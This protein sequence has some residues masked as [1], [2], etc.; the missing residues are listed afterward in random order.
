MDIGTMH[1]E[2]H[3]RRIMLRIAYDGTNY[4]GW[5][6]QENGTAVEEVLNKGLCEL[7]GEEIA[8]IGASRTDSGVHALGNVA[9][10][11]TESRIPAEKFCLAV[12]KYLPDDIAVQSSCEVSPDF[13]PRYAQC[14]KTYEYTIYNA[15]IP[16]P[17][18][19]R[20]SYFVHWPLKVDLMN[21][22]VGYLVGE[23]DFAGFCS[24]G[25]QVKTT[26]REIFAAECVEIKEDL[27][28]PPV[29]DS[30]LLTA[31]HPERK[32]Y[33]DGK[34]KIVIRLTGNGF[35]YNMVRIIAGTLVQ[36]GQGMYPPS[37]MKEIIESC[38]RREAGP[39]APP[40]GLVLKEI[41]Y[42]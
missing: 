14:R 32:A 37:K 11:D 6:K 21:E 16:N 13:H 24:A 39:T 36:I 8:V 29:A 18:T 10:F 30:N 23:H 17:M 38:D 31:L 33:T 41:V 28:I 15:T 22:A 42:F 26:I 9:V 35:L 7:T 25:A 5:Q 2:V 3:M 19:G 27:S 4:V 1:E 40:Q 20:Y 12:N 34:R